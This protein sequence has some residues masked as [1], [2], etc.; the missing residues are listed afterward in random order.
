MESPNPVYKL[1]DLSGKVAIVT[2]GTGVLGSAMARALG[3]AGV[4]VGILG[5]RASKTEEIATSIEEQGGEAMALPADVLQ[6]SELQK[7][8]EM[9][10]EKWGRIDIL[11]NAAGGNMPGA[12]IQPDQSFLDLSEDALQQVVDLNLKGTVLPTKI[13]VQPMIEQKSGVVINISSMAADK[14]MTRVVGYAA[15][16]AAVNNYTLWL[17]T[18]LATKYGEGIRVNAIAPGFFVGEQNRSLLLND[19]GSYT[20][21]GKTIISQTPMGRFGQPDELA[22]TLLW[23][24]SDAARFV[25]GIVVPVDGGF[26]SFSGV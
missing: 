21:R 12:T 19:D 10:M 25:T 7:A 24:C 1:F 18:E 17:S 13:F 20:D 9:V 6:T 3:R 8:R 4:K 5:R 2:G 14:P 22:G 23:L 26:S 11:L 15:A 16:K